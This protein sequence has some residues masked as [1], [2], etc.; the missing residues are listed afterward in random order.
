MSY[1]TIT[2][3]KAR[4]LP[5]G[6]Y[7]AVPDDTIQLELDSAASL[8]DAALVPKHTLPLSTGSFDDNSRIAMIYKAEI[9]MASFTMLTIIGYEP[10]TEQFTSVEAQYNTTLG[11]LERL[12]N[13]QLMLPDSADATPTIAIT[14]NPAS[15]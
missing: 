2:Q 3:F 9:V 1:N 4:S 11:M 12:A 5:T 8:I 13:G 14:I 15:A 7:D 6:S 10:D